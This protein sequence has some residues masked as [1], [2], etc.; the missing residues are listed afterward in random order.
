VEAY[1]ALGLLIDEVL[2]S[3]GYLVRLWPDGANAAACIRQEQPD[4]V[5]LDLW[6]Q[7]RGDGLLILGQLWGDVATRHIPL[8]VFVD[9]THSLPME[10]VLPAAQRLDIVEKPFFLEQLLGRVERALDLALFPSMAAYRD[11]GPAEAALARG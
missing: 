3:E 1:S 7:Q 8:I 4:L 9:D 6:L 10:R 5:I 2:T 11:V